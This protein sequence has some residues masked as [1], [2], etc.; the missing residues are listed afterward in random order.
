[1]HIR[2]FKQVVK[3]LVA[4]LLLADAAIAAQDSDTSDPAVQ[5]KL[6]GNAIAIE[7][8][9]DNYLLQAMQRLEGSCT[10]AAADETADFTA[11]G[12]TLTAVPEGDK[13]LV[14]K[15]GAGTASSE[16]ILIRE[17]DGSTTALL[18]CESSY[19]APIASI[20]QSRRAPTG[21]QDTYVIA[22]AAS[23]DT[24]NLLDEPVAAPARVENT[25]ERLT[26]FEQNSLG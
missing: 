6:G 9:E 22:G 24:T 10:P 8:W 23:S 7:T 14:F 4:G 26:A 18:D 13:T 5:L 1:M 21:S 11:S 19:S 3:T 25:T 12:D 20:M 15:L 17:Q 16:F 2:Y